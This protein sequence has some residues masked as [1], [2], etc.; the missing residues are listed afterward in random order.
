VF[1]G[2]PGNEITEEAA[3]RAAFV[4]HIHD[5]HAYGAAFK[6]KFVGHAVTSLRFN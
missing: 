5:F 6:A 4:G 1:I 3:R 2:I